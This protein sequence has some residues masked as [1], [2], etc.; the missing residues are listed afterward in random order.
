MGILQGIALGL[1][2]LIIRT[3][4]A[5]VIAPGESE[6]V[7]ATA[8]EIVAG[9]IGALAFAVGAAA[10]MGR[11]RLTPVVVTDTVTGVTAVTGC[12]MVAMLEL[13]SAAKGVT[14]AETAAGTGPTVIGVVH[15]AGTVTIAIGT[16]GGETTM[17]DDDIVGR[18]NYRRNN[19]VWFA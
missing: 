18:S 11:R 3:A 10:E 17:A 15:A 16:S 6:T 8:T 7:I 9:E 19:T 1:L 5:T 14:G 2:H 13:W 4:T 12:E